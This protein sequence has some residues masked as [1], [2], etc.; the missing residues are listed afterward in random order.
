[1]KYLRRN[2][3]RAELAESHSM[4][5][6]TINRTITAV[7]DLLADRLVEKPLSLDQAPKDISLLIDGTLLPCWSW[8]AEKI[9]FSGKRRH[10]SVNVQVV[11]ET[12]GNLQWISPILKESVHG[13]KAFDTHEIFNHLNT[14]NIIA[15]KGHIGRGFHTLTRTQPG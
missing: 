2:H 12:H 3:I 1:M 7:T 13:A 14:R 9:I 8:K 6:S 11:T 5:Q 4:S 10:S 15:D